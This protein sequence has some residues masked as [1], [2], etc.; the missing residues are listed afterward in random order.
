MVLFLSACGR[1]EVYTGSGGFGGT[2]G[3]GGSGGE[4]GTD[5]GTCPTQFCNDAGMPVCF[6]NSDCPGSLAY[7]C[8]TVHCDPTGSQTATGSPVI[9]CYY[10]DD[11]PD[12]DCIAGNVPGKCVP[13]HNQLVCIPTG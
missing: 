4:G 9:G 10:L 8:H 13:I 1:C 2:G 5:A 11:V 12:A 7:S 6:L 3:A